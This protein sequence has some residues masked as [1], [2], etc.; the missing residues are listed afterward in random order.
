MNRKREEAVARE[1]MGLMVTAFGSG[2]RRKCMRVLLFFFLFARYESTYLWV[3]FDAIKDIGKQPKCVVL[4]SFTRSLFVPS[5]RSCTVDKLKSIFDWLSN[6]VCQNHCGI[7]VRECVYALLSAISFPFRLRTFIYRT[8]VFYLNFAALHA[9][10][11]ASVR[12][13]RLLLSRLSYRR[14]RLWLF[15]G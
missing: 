13:R 5:A 9:C 8:N 4:S 2:I 10:L 11:D 14:P 7:F 15:R 6:E 3:F 1:K 12:L